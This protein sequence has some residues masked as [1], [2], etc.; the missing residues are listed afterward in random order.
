[1]SGSKRLVNVEENKERA[2]QGGR[3]GWNIPA[4]VFVTHFVHDG[5]Q[6]LL[7]GGLLAFPHL[8]ALLLEIRQQLEDLKE[9]A[10][11]KLIVF[12]KPK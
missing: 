3:Q 8:S 10:I 11:C 5:V 9:P 4:N 2:G 7:A 6:V 1:M 12:T